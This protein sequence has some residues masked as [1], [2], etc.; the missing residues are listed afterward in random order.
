MNNSNQNSLSIKTLL[1]MVFNRNASDLHLCVGTPPTLRIDGNLVPIP[2][3]PILTPEDTKRLAYSILTDEQKEMLEKEKEIDL[4]YSLENKARFRVNI[5]HQ[6]GY[7]SIALRYLP[8]KIP[9]LEEL[10][11]PSVCNEFTK[12]SQGFVLVTGPTGHGKS[13][14]LASM[15]NK[16]NQERAC[17]IITIEDPIEYV[18]VHNKSIID[19]RELHLDTHSFARAL[20]SVLREDPDVVLIGEMRDLETIAA[21]ITIA[22]TG[23]LVFATLH[24]NS[25]AQTVDRIIDVF[26]AHQQPTIRTQLSN[27]LLGIISQRLLP[28]IGGGRIL[29]TEVLFANPAVRNLIREG[30][31]YQIQNIIQTGKEENMISL[32]K[33]LARL[34]QRGEITIETGE[35]FA[36]DVKFFHKLVAAQIIE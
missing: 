3:Q 16:I 31:S 34:V 18:F 23:H 28:R 5:Y 12:H 2:N 35:S 14:T 1:E 8:Y 9:T 15:I 22:E 6:K 33:N 21:A 32:D 24:T 13:T 11:L 26:P 20:R 25:A 29:A 4:S 17:H 19:Q 30:K 7:I 36:V 27:I 10:G